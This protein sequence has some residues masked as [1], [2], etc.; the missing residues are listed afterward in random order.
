M[1]YETEE[2]NKRRNRRIT[3]K[4]SRHLHL[5]Q[6]TCRTSQSGSPIK[7]TKPTGAKARCGNTQVPRN[8]N[9]PFTYKKKLLKQLKSWQN[10]LDLD[11]AN[12]PYTT[13]VAAHSTRLNTHNPLMQYKWKLTHPTHPLQQGS[14]KAAPSMQDWGVVPHPTQYQTHNQAKEHLPP[15]YLILEAM[16]AKPYQEGKHWWGGE[17]RRLTYVQRLQRGTTTHSIWPIKKCKDGVSIILAQESPIFSP[18]KHSWWGWGSRT[19]W[20]YIRSGCP[21]PVKEL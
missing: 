8:H 2:D 17:G 11:A 6:H 14:D 15:S 19:V 5:P 1:K 13:E 9:P 7:L 16:K 18:H 3:S 20:P 12:P 4:N 21:V 10:K